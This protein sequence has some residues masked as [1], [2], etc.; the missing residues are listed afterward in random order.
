M[1]ERTAVTMTTSL[2]FFVRSAALPE[3]NVDAITMKGCERSRYNV[4][5]MVRFKMDGSE[6]ETPVVPWIKPLGVAC[7]NGMAHDHPEVKPFCH[8]T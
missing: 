3:S 2:S 5:R 8:L 7:D 4:K 6:E 1:A